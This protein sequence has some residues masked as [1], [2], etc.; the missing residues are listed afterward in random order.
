MAK[1]RLSKLID[2]YVIRKGHKF[3]LKEIDPGDTQ[4][5]KPQKEVARQVLEEGIVRLR[6]LQEKL[7]AQ[8]RW[9]VLLMFQAMDAAGKGGAVEH[10]MTG[11]N[12]AG[13]QV[14]SFKAPSAE[15]RDHDFLW[16]N[17][18]C[19]PERGRIGIFDRS[20][21]EEVLIVRIHPEILEG[22][23]IP[24]ELKTKNIWQERFEDICAFERYLAR[25]GYVIRK[26]FL[27]IS[28]KEQ[29]GRFRKRL[30]E[31]EKNWKF[32]IGD[33]AERARWKDYMKA[34]EDVIQHTATPYAPWVVVPG[35]KKWFAR[36]IVAAT[37]VDALEELD[38]KYPKITGSK[39]RELEQGRK[40]LDK[41]VRK[42]GK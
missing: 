5:F 10:V 32:N 42:P 15:E 22:Q 16:R 23:K 11:V 26:F 25:Q 41:A 31:P 9:G 27:H 14:Y 17:F 39:R 36:I 33:L 8:D 35:N 40:L 20:Y 18:R 6:D 12:P 37:V 7:H 34:Y 19:L 29:L 1:S 2:P 30:D 3:R 28:Q 24:D 21:Y 13:V 4:G 38:L